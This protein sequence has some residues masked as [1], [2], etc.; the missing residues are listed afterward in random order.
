MHW[1]L[2]KSEWDKAGVVER[3]VET[4]LCETLSSIRKNIDVVW[5]LSV[6]GRV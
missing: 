6:L 3:F 2:C 4:L 5:F 1:K